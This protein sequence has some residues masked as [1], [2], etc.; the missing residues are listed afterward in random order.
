MP[1]PEESTAS[2]MYR[3]ARKV[4]LSDE[5][6]TTEEAIRLT[7]RADEIA[8]LAIA[9]RTAA[10]SDIKAEVDQALRDLNEDIADIENAREVVRKVREAIKVIDGLILAAADVMA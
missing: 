2:E 9:M 7:R 3:A 10:Y 1:S 8:R 4:A 5:P 6:G